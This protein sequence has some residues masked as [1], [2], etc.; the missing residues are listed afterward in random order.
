MLWIL[1]ALGVCL[2]ALLGFLRLRSAKK[3]VKDIAF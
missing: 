3:T 1:F 2:A